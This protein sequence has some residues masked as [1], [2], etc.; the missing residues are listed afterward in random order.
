M[1]MM[2]KMRMSSDM[3]FTSQSLDGLGVGP[4]GEKKSGNDCYDD[5]IIHMVASTGYDWGMTIV[6]GLYT[7]LLAFFSF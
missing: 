4:C 7:T 2:M 6:V 3:F 1:Q 5:P